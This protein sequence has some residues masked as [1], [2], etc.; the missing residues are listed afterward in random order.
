MHALIAL[1]PGLVFL[2]AL[3]LMDTFRLV[4]ARSIAVALL[5]GAGAALTCEMLHLWLLPASGLD[6]PSFSRYVAP[7][8]EE[9]AKAI[10]VAVLIARGRVGFLVD[11]AVLG[12]AVGTGFA[13]VENIG[14]LRA[15]AE[16]P[17]VLWA[18]RGLGTGVLHAAT[19]AIAA[20]VAKSMS[21]QRPRAPLAAA[22][23]GLALAAI[24]HSIYNHLLAFPALAAVATLVALPVVVAVVF[25]RSERATR[26]WVGAGLDLDLTL[27]QLIVSDGFQGT[28]FARYLGALPE[29][30]EGAVVAD[31]FCLLRIELELAIQ[32]KARLIA[33]QAGLDLP[34]HPDVH[35]ALAE[36]RYLQESIG[37]TGLLALEPLRVTSH[38]DYW[39]QH[40]LS[41]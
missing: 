1:A 31:M 13:M 18:V 12:F 7:L 22:L 26:E 5:Y 38:R 17:L 40:V 6:A 21:E 41:H 34:V 36:R 27:L 8:T 20:I 11:A 9:T 28:R 15:L 23:P 25:E 3:W 24:L 14:Y 4:R 19:T 32:A 2:A 10:F 16:A 33:K 29:R 39:H 35:A 37:R 30:F